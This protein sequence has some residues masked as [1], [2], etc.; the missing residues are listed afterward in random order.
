M[1]QSEMKHSSPIW[2]KL[3]ALLV[4]LLGVIGLTIGPCWGARQAP[5]WAAP[6]QSPYAQT[7]PTR[8]LTPTLPPEPT[9]ASEPEEE[10]SE[11]NDDASPTPLPVSL[12]PLRVESP[13][14]APTPDK[15][16]TL[17]VASPAPIE[18]AGPSEA[19]ADPQLDYSA[20]ALTATILDTGEDTS[21]HSTLI[22]SRSPRVESTSTD[23]T[24]RSV[25]SE[26]L[27]SV[28]VDGPEQSLESPMPSRRASPLLW[29]YAT[30]LG[31]LL[32]LGGAFLINRS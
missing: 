11:D 25:L 4:V 18:P 16:P 1:V 10:P 3:R 14:P 15:S 19:V 9:P 5:S 8:L 12:T 2:P 26:T 13:I 30:G 29:L 20:A 17:A 32:I 28:A 22:P 23:E 6:G 27:A 21:L 31:L 24:E 7:V